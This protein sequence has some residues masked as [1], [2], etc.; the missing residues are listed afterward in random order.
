MISNHSTLKLLVWTALVFSGQVNIL[1]KNFETTT[2]ATEN[3]T[4]YS[5]TS[6]NSLIPDDNNDTSELRTSATES[7]IGKHSTE[8]NSTHSNTEP[9]Q[10]WTIPNAVMTT[11]NGRWISGFKVEANDNVSITNISTSMVNESRIS[12]SNGHVT[13]SFE[14]E[15]SADKDHLRDAMIASKDTDHEGFKMSK[16]AQS[17]PDGELNKELM[18]G[19]VTNANT[20]STTGGTKLLN[21]SRTITERSTT[22]KPESTSLKGLSFF[23]WMSTVS[24]TESLLQEQP[25]TSSSSSLKGRSTTS[26][27]A[28]SMRL[29]RDSASSDDEKTSSENDR[30]INWKMSQD[31]TV[32]LANDT[33]FPNNTN[34]NGTRSFTSWDDVG[35]ALT[36]TA[37]DKHGDRVQLSLITA[38]FIII[39]TAMLSFVVFQL[40]KLYSKSKRQHEHEDH[41]LAEK[42]R[43]L[44][45]TVLKHKVGASVGTEVPQYQFLTTG[46]PQGTS[47]RVIPSILITDCTG[48]VFT[49]SEFGETA[50]AQKSV[51][52]S[53]GRLPDSMDQLDSVGTSED[54]SLISS[55]GNAGPCPSNVDMKLMT[56]K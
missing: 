3:N 36:G 9:I 54:P 13:T 32:L 52:F 47:S 51:S 25:T 34:R 50:S 21:E 4:K 27:S 28:K 31:G 19:S 8:G 15:L 33:Y 16:T 48:S 40:V 45:R 55:C 17:K 46:P 53:I 5:P 41:E 24:A 38:V 30:P 49:K 11:S 1:A 22:L 2:N 14:S 29:L 20:G 39:V 6:V 18:T 43:A 23:K 12:K 37:S 42:R 10:N 7:L 44:R 26:R 56:K 35:N